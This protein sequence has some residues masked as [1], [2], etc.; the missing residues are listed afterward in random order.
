MRKSHI[1][2][3]GLLLSGF[4][5]VAYLFNLPKFIVEETKEGALSTTKEERTAENSSSNHS[6]QEIDTERI[7]ELTTLLIN[8]ENLEKK[9]IFADSIAQRYRKTMFFDSSAKYFELAAT[10]NPVAPNIQKAADGIFEAFQN[11]M[12]AEARKK[13]GTKAI[14]FLD[15]ILEEDPSNVNAEIRKAVALVYTEPMPMGGITLLKKIINEN[16]KNTEARLYLG[17]FQFTVGKIDAAI[18]QFNIVHD[19]DPM[20]FKALLYLT[21]G[22]ISLGKKEK[23]EKYI[24]EIK[25]LESTDPYIKSV[26]EQFE[27]E[28]K[29]L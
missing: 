4:L 26:L 18:E 9:A 20:D 1:I 25:A 12:T 27:S 17:E 24:K 21:D 8:S 14:G 11:S 7:E 3:I 10:L 15:K 19:L 2:Q 29:K 28:L 5:F 16:P 22:Y 23:A 6:S 13:L